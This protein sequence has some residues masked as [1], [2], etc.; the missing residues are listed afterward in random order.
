MF[1]GHPRLRFR[2]ESAAE[3]A[4]EALQSA[5][6]CRRHTNTGTV[7]LPGQTM[8]LHHRPACPRIQ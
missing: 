3:A 5:D 1:L 4:T 2:V 7:G 8:S 6:T